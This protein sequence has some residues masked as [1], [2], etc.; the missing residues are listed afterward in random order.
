M[1]FVAF[2]SCIGDE[3]RNEAKIGADWPGFIGEFE[4]FDA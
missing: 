2:F 3:T 4:D 1:A